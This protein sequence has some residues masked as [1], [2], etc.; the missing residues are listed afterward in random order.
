MF[1]EQRQWVDRFLSEKK[2]QLVDKF[3][4]EKKEKMDQMLEE[5]T[6]EWLKEARKEQRNWEDLEAALE[7]SRATE[8][9]IPKMG[10]DGIYQ[11]GNERQF[12]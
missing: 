11:I 4:N 2:E 9:G 10:K 8:K 7:S 6:P 3:I 5:M 12:Q 1:D